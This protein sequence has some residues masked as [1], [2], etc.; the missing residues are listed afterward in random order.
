VPSPEALKELVEQDANELAWIAAQFPVG[1]VI[2]RRGNDLQERPRGR[3]SRYIP[4]SR[5][6]LEDESSDE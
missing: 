1:A 3:R 6:D 5:A 4:V 2:E